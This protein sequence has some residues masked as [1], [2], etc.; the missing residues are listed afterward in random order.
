MTEGQSDIGLVFIVSG[1]AG[2]GKTTLCNRMLSELHPRVQRVITATTRPPREGE[3]DGVDYYFLSQEEF[4]KRVNAGEFY[5]HAKVHT[6]NYGI[7]K[8]EITKKL[9]QNIDLLINIDVQGARTLRK[10]AEEDPQLKGRVIS[11]F[12]MPQS[13]EEL[14]T[15]LTGRGLDENEEI[16]R[17]LKVAEN[18]VKDWNR[19]DYSIP[20]GTKEEDFACLMSLYAAEKLRVRN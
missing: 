15:R 20:S 6:Y 11:I 4:D 12:V 8:K 1:P 10:A 19:Y 3:N 5:E 2:S 9:E 7:L 18:E 13:V 14:R 16:E 17:R